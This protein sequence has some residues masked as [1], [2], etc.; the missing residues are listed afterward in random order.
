MSRPRFKMRKTEDPGQDP[1]WQ[2]IMLSTSWQHL[3]PVPHKRDPLQQ[4]SA[5]HEKSPPCTT[6]LCLAREVSASRE[7]LPT[8]TEVWAMTRDTSMGHKSLHHDAWGNDSS[9][10]AK[11]PTSG[12]CKQLAPTRALMR[13][14]PAAQPT[15]QPLLG[16]DP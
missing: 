15:H 14:C 1:H 9:R 7:L 11:A 12:P 13:V 4:V 3:R 8:P 10:H 16:I 5:S 6:S 2:D